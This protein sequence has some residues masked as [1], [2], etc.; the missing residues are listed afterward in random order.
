[1]SCGLVSVSNLQQSS[2]ERG[3]GKKDLFENLVLAPIAWSGGLTI[4]LLP[5]DQAISMI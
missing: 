3:T 4:K 2:I 1:M 5:Y